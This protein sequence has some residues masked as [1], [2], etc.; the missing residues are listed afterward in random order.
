M[1]GVIIHVV[2]I[3]LLSFS[4]SSQAV[5]ICESLSWEKESKCILK[6]LP[7]VSSFLRC[8]CDSFPLCPLQVNE[9]S[10]EIVD[11][12]EATNILRAMRGKV[13]Y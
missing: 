11:Q 13:R 3:L 10:L 2:D 4:S 1:R 8:L 12:T 7:F 9:H 6:A 5:V